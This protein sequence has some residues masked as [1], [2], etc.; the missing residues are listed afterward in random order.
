MK[1]MPP[2][3]HVIAAILSLAAFVTLAGLALGA[4]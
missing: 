3:S 2:V 1:Q 4:G